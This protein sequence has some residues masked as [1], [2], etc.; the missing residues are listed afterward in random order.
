MRPI[1]S[2]L[3]A[4]VLIAACVL[5]PQEEPVPARPVLPPLEEGVSLALAQHRAATIADVHYELELDVRHP[6]TAWGNVRIR[7]QRLPGA[8]PL[9]LDFAGLALGPVAV[10]GRAFAPAWWL[11]HL[12]VPTE[13]L[14]PGAN[15]IELDFA[16]AIAP[17]GASIIRFDDRAD[18][19]RYLYTL[20][21]PSDGH[22][23]FP[24]FDQPDLKAKVTL[25][26][27]APA[28]WRVVANGRDAGRVD[29]PDGVHWSFAET[30][31]ISTYLIAFAAGPWTVFGDSVRLFTRASRAADVDADEFIG[32]NLR[33]LN[34]LEQYF[35][36]AYPF[37]KLDLVMAP[38]F[39]FGG[40]EHVGAIFYNESRFV[41]REPPTQVQRL[42]RASTVYH[43]IAHQWFGDLVTMR[44]FDDLWLKE[45]F[46]TFVAAKIQQELDPGS[47][48][49]KTFHLRTK[50]PAY[51]VDATT[52][53]T[54]VWQQLTNLELAKSNYGPIVYNKAP[55]IL[56]QLEFLVGAEAFRSGMSLFLRR[57]AFGVAGWQDLLAAIGEAAGA[58]LSA[59][60]EHYILR[61]GM[62]V[63]ETELRLRAGSI[64]E[65]AL[66]QRPAR[67]LPGDIGGWWP[68]RVRVL[69]GYAD[70][71]RVVD[72][73]FTGVRTV[74]GEVAGL[75]APEYVLPNQGDYGYGLFLPD[76]RSGRWLLHNA[77]AIADPLDRAVAWSGV[78]ELVREGRLAAA[79]YAHALLA[80]LPREVDEQI[81]SSQL[82][83]LLQAVGRYMP[84][85]A[86]QD[87][88]AAALETLL[89]HTAA[90]EALPYGRRKEAL[91]ALLA[92]ARTP[93]GVSTVESFLDGR[94]LFNGEPLAQPSRWTA[95]RRLV[96]L[97]APRSA[98][99]LVAE[100]RRDT[101]PDGP[102]MAFVTGAAV[103]A[104]EAKAEYFRR[105]FEDSSL[106]EEWVT[107][108]LDA[109]NEAQHAEL[110][111]PYVAPA[112]ARAEWIRDHRR[113]FFLPTWINSFVGAR[114]DRAGLRA[115]DAFL[116]AQP[117]LA[118]DVRRRILQARDELER[119]VRL[120]GD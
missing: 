15:E 48:A 23:L 65:L 16:A 113:I 81:A 76:A 90:D 89:I 27:L 55:A 45:G 92:T 13:H 49:W 79:E 41:F 35:G 9:V 103:P 109:F 86:E 117:E 11:G 94:I 51:V 10:N 17:A 28:G 29:R 66:V 64:E 37:D 3:T 107:A 7:F 74:V 12:L 63:I 72:V 22:R 26:V 32:L 83:R 116:A 108:S 56:K 118:P 91:D 80:A 78:W 62:P 1:L 43:E 53:T 110:T 67:Q 14:R 31:P 6:D 120:Q 104:P 84:R 88:L 52:G 58:D 70:A 115:V 5:G 34:W 61:A 85:G 96:A 102:R 46:S 33:A 69:L 95:V 106:N 8:G 50:P 98:E 93:A 39:P 30:A 111:L 21:V 2:V 112:L 19:S 24:S 97:A 87:R 82:A 75:P 71:E 54:P 4:V 99:L 119:A 47:G 101:T 68:G 57:H 38:A 73:E 44:W 59:F 25:G 42:G 100:I 40:M 18:G 36:I 60:G 105:Y 114:A 77:G 20:L